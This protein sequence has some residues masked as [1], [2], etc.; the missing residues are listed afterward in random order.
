MNTSSGVPAIPLETRYIKA[1]PQLP[2]RAGPVMKIGLEA[3]STVA[4]G[5]GPDVN[6]L[7]DGDALLAQFGEL[8][9]LVRHKIGSNVDA[10][11]ADGTL[12]GLVIQP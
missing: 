2:S 11:I 7:Y 8:E 4:L 9:N 12:V 5:D 6:L 3:L 10:L 1:L